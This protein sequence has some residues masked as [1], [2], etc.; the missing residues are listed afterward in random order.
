[1]A[2]SGPS[3]RA[4]KRVVGQVL[5]GGPPDAPGQR[6]DLRPA[7]RS[8]GCAQHTARNSIWSALAP[9]SASKTPRWDVTWSRGEPQRRRLPGRAGRGGCPAPACHD[10]PHGRPCCRRQNGD[11]SGEGEEPEEVHQA[12]QA[13]SVRPQDYCGGEQGQEGTAAGGWRQRRASGGAEGQ[14]DGRRLGC[15]RLPPRS[16][17]HRAACLAAPFACPAAGA[18]EAAQGY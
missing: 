1:M 4:A 7:G 15:G 9:R 14:H 10:T 18:L 8:P 2:R 5:L 12:L 17:A 3:G 6:G 16:P 11:S 13:P